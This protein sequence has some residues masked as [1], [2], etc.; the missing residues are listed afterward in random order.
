MKQISSNIAYPNLPLTGAPMSSA[1]SGGLTREIAESLS[2]K[3]S[4][5]EMKAIINMDDLLKK[6]TIKLEYANDD[7]EN[8]SSKLEGILT[9]RDFL[10]D[11]L[12]NAE[13]A[14]KISLV[15]NV[16]LRKQASADQEVIHYLDLRSQEFEG[17]NVELTARSDQLQAAYNLQC[18]S[19]SYRE[20]QLFGEL[21]EY[22]T[23]YDDLEI[24]Y[25]SHK[26]ILV[27]EVKSLRNKL[28]SLMLERNKQKT[29]LLTLRNVLELD[30]EI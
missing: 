11:K 2:K 7:N 26:R 13:I 18:G 9:M 21:A 22:K 23:K 30:I 28:D 3:L 17:K 29:Q 12:K 15:E 6:N 24:M 10:L 4:A 14:L 20:S 5:T 19:Y 27:K 25:K 8:L 1:H 16:T